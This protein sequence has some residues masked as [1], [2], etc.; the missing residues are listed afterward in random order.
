[1]K[2]PVFIGTAYNKRGTTH[3]MVLRALRNV[4]FFR[5]N[6]TLTHLPLEIRG[7]TGIIPTVQLNMATGCVGPLLYMTPM[8][9]SLA[10]M[11]TKLY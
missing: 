1:M 3:K 6:R 9:L 7:H 8:R 2:P 11:K 10:I 4:H 5:A